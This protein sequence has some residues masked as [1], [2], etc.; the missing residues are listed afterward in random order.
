MGDV[1]LGKFSTSGISLSIAIAAS[2]GFPPIL[3]P[4]TIRLPTDVKP[5]GNYP[6]VFD[7]GRSLFAPLSLEGTGGRIILADG[8][9]GDNL[10]LESGYSEVR[11]LVGSRGVYVFAS[12]G[13]SSSIQEDNPGFDWISQFFRSFG[14]IFGQGDFARVQRLI[15]VSQD[16]RRT[17]SMSTSSSPSD[18]VKPEIRLPL[19]DSRAQVLDGLYWSVAFA[20]YD[21]ARSWRGRW[22]K[23]RLPSWGNGVTPLNIPRGDLGCLARV[24]TR[25]KLVSPVVGLQLENWGYTSFDNA[26]PFLSSLRRLEGTHTTFYTRHARRWSTAEHFAL[27]NPDAGFGPCIRD[28]WWN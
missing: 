18:Q 10:E 8:G 3:S 9:V 4:L 17:I 15:S 25:L 24:G 26:L 21:H 19:S 22:T 5:I 14:I 13:G 7:H 1:T 11:G 16:A 2:S 20:P 12:D 27:P 23:F 28:R 6:S